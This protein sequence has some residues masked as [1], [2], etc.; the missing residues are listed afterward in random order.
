MPYLE[1]AKIISAPLAGLVGA[2]GASYLTNKFSERRFD[3][4]AE[5]E[6]LKE[7]QKILRDKGE[8]AFYAVKQWGKQIYFFYSAR[9]G[10]LQGSITGE[11]LDEVIDKRTNPDTHAQLDVL[12]G[13]YFPE[14]MEELEAVHTKLDK[15]NRVYGLFESKV[16]TA[17]EAHN[18]L[19]NPVSEAENALDSLS[20]KL[21]EH[22]ASN[23]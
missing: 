5:Q 9:L 14:F 1:I 11:K 6:R 13:I 15:C 17:K 20:E 3:K 22:L 16:M 7:R 12:I 8:Q 10:Y 4:Q 2:F 23:N 19:I 21:R 18:N